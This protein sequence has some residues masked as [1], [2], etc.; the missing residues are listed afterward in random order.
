[1]KTVLLISASLAMAYAQ[2]SVVGD[3]IQAPGTKVDNSAAAHTLPAKVG[4]GAN[5]PLTCTV[6]EEYFATDA[7][8]GQNLLHCS[9]ANVWTGQSAGGPIF[10]ASSGTFKVA[11]YPAAVAGGGDRRKKQGCGDTMINNA[12]NHRRPRC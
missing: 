9:A 8:P 4:P 12:R 7:V 5:K 10:P 11:P 2:R 1:M 6:G 3:R